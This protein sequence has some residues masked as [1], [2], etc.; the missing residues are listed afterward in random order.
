MTVR[1]AIRDL[2]AARLSPAAATPTPDRPAAD[3]PT[4][5]GLGAAAPTADGAGGEALTPG[6]AGAAALASDT[7][8][9]GDDRWFCRPGGVGRVGAG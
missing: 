8:G 2:L 1:D 7:A 4:P 9:G 5:G 6:G 3:A